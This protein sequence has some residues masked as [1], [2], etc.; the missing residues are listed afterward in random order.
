[1][2][3]ILFVLCAAALLCS[4]APK[5]SG[6]AQQAA[7]SFLTGYLSMD[8]EGIDAYCDSLVLSNLNRATEGWQNLDT[9]LLAKMKEAAAKTRFEI[10]SV[11]DDETEKGK[12]H[13]KY[14]LY[15]MGNDHGQ[16]MSLTLTKEG[17]K[18][19]V[20]SLR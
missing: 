16:E 3:K 11:E 6:K 14:M 9:A 1:M 5:G 4:C 8:M 19:L 13:V 18:W 17:G 20:S 12:A 7:E 2:K 15:P 10:V